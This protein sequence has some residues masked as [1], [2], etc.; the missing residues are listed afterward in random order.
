MLEALLGTTI[1]LV[2]LLGLVRL[3]AGAIAR[4]TV[5][6]AVDN[7][8]WSAAFDAPPQDRRPTLE[9]EWLGWRAKDEQRGL[10]SLR[11]DRGGL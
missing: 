2:L 1:L 5:Q 10:R 4:Q 9:R 6:Q 7:R 11:I 3:G 8:A